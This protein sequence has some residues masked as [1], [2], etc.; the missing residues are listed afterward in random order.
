MT[1]RPITYA[2]SL[3]LAV[4]IILAGLAPSCGPNPQRTT[5]LPFSV[6]IDSPPPEYFGSTGLHLYAT[7]HEPDGTFVLD[8]YC[9]AVDLYKAY[10]DLAT[11]FSGDPNAGPGSDN[12][13][14][15]PVFGHPRHGEMLAR[16]P[17]SA[18]AQVVGFLTAEEVSLVARRLAELQLETEADV[19]ARYARLNASVRQYLSGLT[20]GS[21]EETARELAAYVLPL[22]R[23][24]RKAAKDEHAVL[25]VANA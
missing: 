17:A 25:F 21:D 24:Y 16:V 11:F 6:R 18:D 8:A 13:D 20:G 22:V 5:L 3:A 19:S 9:E 1:A 23:F 2:Y 14:V 4:L 7:S 12:L 15:I 10:S